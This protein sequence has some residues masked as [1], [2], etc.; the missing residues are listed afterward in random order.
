MRDI[1]HERRHINRGLRADAGAD[2]QNVEPQC[3]QFIGRRQRA[4]HHLGRDPDRERIHD[5]AGC[6]KCD[7]SRTRAHAGCRAKCSRAEV[8]ARSCDDAHAPAVAFVRIECAPG[9]HEPEPVR[10]G[11]IRICAGVIEVRSQCAQWQH[12]EPPDEIHR[13]I[14]DESLFCKA[15]CEGVICDDARAIRGTGVAVQASRNIEAK[16]DGFAILTTAV[17]CT[18]DVAQR[19]VQRAVCTDSE[20]PVENHE[21]LAFDGVHLRNLRT[22]AGCRHRKFRL[23]QRPP[24]GLWKRRDKPHIP[25]VRRKMPRRHERI[26]AIVPFSKDSGTHSRPREKLP[27]ST[28]DLQAGFLHQQV[29]GNA[30]RKRALFAFLHRSAGEDHRELAPSARLAIDGHNRRC[31]RLGLLLPECR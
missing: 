17:D 26:A 30:A 24:C 27:H 5:I 21:R 1:P 22:S 18:G 28:R 2:C 23:W 6:I 11:D 3:E 16:Y 13:A 31:D 14:R 20:E 7:E 15:N 25:S 9:Q 12:T 8:A 10:R 29:G 19:R 4:H